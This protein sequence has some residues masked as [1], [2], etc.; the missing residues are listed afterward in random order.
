[1]PSPGVPAFG[2]V[3]DPEAQAR[4]EAPARRGEGE[5]P[6]QIGT[7]FDLARLR[8]GLKPFRLHW[9]TRLRSTND[10]AA[11]LRRRGELFA[12]AVLLA[13][14]QI[15]GRG[16]GDNVWWSAPG[17]LTVTIALPIDD[18]I[19]PHQIPLIAG[20]A[21]RNAAAEL[22]GNQDILLKW[23]NDI[24]FGERKL[25]GLLCERILRADLVGIGLN[26]NV[27]IS[28]A[29]LPVRSRMTTLAAVCNHRIDPTDA[30]LRI[31]S[32]L[33]AMLQRGANRPFAELLK[34]YDSHHALIG[35]RISVTNVPDPGVLSGKCRGLDSSGRL[36][37]NDGRTVHRILSGQVVLR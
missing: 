21:V 19:A 24:L 35:R 33:R 11:A 9:F 10:H 8:R 22:T 12:P 23:P 18:Q 31:A 25:G 17:C 15:A 5:I 27:D 36:L 16:R 32:H 3:F 2:S 7:G 4:R 1:V 20:L 34:E 13:G 14:R 30:L 29:P 26:L 28:A 6:S 37:L